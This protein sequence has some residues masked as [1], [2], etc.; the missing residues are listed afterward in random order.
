M[1]K[2]PL[3]SKIRILATGEKQEQLISLTAR[4]VEKILDQKL[5]SPMATRGEIDEP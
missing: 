2:P 5:T 3:T 1:P 4:L